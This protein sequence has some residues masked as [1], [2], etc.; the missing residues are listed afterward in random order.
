MASLSFSNVTVRRGATRRPVLSNFSWSFDHFPLALLGPNGA[1]KSTILHTAAGALRPS[2]GLVATIDP[3][4][5][6]I[7]SSRG[8]RRVV[9]LV[10]QD[11]RG[12]SGLNVREAVAYAGWLKGLSRSHAWDRSEWCLE[13]LNLMKQARARSTQLSGGEQRRLSIAQGLVA[14]PAVLLL[15]EV[16]T[17]LDPAERE[18]LIAIVAELSAS[19]PVLATTH[20]VDDLDEVFHYVAVLSEGSV[21]YENTTS[22]FFRLGS[23]GRSSRDQAAT[24]YRVALERPNPNSPT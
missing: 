20:E 17:G 14:D 4:G 21:V 10:P 8:R 23:A 16:T 5:K 11:A 3:D 22:D 15:D 2:R 13:R 7:E 24:A 6:M 12:F 19:K 1:G 18:N 9:G